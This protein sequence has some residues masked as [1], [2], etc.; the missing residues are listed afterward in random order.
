[1]EDLYIL[2]YHRSRSFTFI[3]FMQKLSRNGTL[4][5]GR[6]GGGVWA[7]L[8]PDCDRSW[9]CGG[10]GEVMRRSWAAATAGVAIPATGWR[11]PNNT[12]HREVLRTLGTR[13]GRLGGGG[14]SCNRELAVGAPMVG[15]RGSVGGAQRGRARGH[16]VARFYRRRK[17][18]P[19]PWKEP[20][21]FNS[22][23]G[24]RPRP[25]RTQGEPARTGGQCRA[26]MV[27]R[28]RTPR[29]VGVDFKGL[30]V[31]SA[32]GR[33]G[34]GKARG[35]PDAEVGGAHAWA[36]G[37]AG[38]RA[39]LRSADMCRTGNVWLRLTRNFS[40]KVHQ[41]VNRKVVYLTTLYNFYKGS[42]VF[43][44]TDFA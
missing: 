7:H 16:G 5:R 40:T 9:G 42:R 27:A 17:S 10:A 25:A 26:R 8:G 32:S 11:G 34:L 28:A 30:R 12:R 6:C 39:V 37:C 43:F 2:R 33:S 22:Q 23:Y 21:T 18:V 14:T 19:S 36:R 24:E 1:M 3:F 15:R 41:V 20:P 38:A 29:G 44:S 35:G 13:F 4:G 31:L